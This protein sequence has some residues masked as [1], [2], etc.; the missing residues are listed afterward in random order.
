[1][2]GPR[3]TPLYFMVIKMILRVTQPQCSGLM[4]SHD[5][6]DRGP[7][8][9]SDSPQRRVVFFDV[10]GVLIDS[11]ELKGE[12]FAEAFDDFR[13]DWCVAA[14]DQNELSATALDVAHSA[15]QV[16]EEG[17]TGT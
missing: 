5:S 14:A 11:M 12:A 6:L 4:L 7:L 17:C 15:V 16:V 10:D 1:M 8:T 9:S 2:V 13:G 3:S